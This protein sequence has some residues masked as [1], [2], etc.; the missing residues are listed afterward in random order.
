MNEEIQELIE[1]KDIVYPIQFGFECG[2]GWYWL[3]DQLMNTIYKYCELNHKEFPNVIQIKEKY[4]ALCFYIQGSN[5]IID[6]MIWQAEAMSYHI[7]ETCGTNKGVGQTEGWIY[8]TCWDCLEKN[9]RAKD[10]KWKPNENK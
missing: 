7:C 5:E 2:D 10:L 3:L 6:G 8:T 4:G 1:Q 9:E